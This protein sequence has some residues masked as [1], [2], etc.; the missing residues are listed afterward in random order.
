M[1]AIYLNDHRAGSTVGLELARRARGSNE[2]SQ[3]GAFLE[4]LVAEIEEDRETLEQ[5]MDAV[6]AGRDRL[7]ATAAW[8]GEKVGRLKLNGRLFG[9]SPL[10]RVVELESLS[11]G[12]EGKACLWRMLR[13]L[14]DPRLAGFDFDALIAR[15]ERQRDEV[16]G[17]R[18]A[19]GREALT[20][21]E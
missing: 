15:A 17:H 1:L 16:E 6:G 20:L 5:V 21:A 19:A 11:V 8:A 13:D 4:R 2:G 12:I 14:G 9:Y 18:L 3:L 7:K 10:S